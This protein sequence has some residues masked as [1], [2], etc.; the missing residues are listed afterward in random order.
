[1]AL[2]AKRI[3]ESVAHLDVETVAAAFTRHDANVRNTARALGVPSVDLRKLVLLDQRLSDAAL[4]AIELRLD[5][6]E[7]RSA[8]ARP[9]RPRGRPR[10]NDG[11]A[12]AGEDSYHWVNEHT[13]PRYVEYWDRLDEGLRK[14]GLPE[15]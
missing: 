4:E 11:R 15:E 12:E 6:C 8:S 7:T 9:C 14:A 3:P 1:M 5:D 10:K 13:D 2:P